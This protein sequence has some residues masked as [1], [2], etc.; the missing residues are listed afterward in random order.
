MVRWARISDRSAVVRGVR[1]AVVHRTYRLGR[2]WPHL[3]IAVFDNFGERRL[4][5]MS[6]R[7]SLPEQGFALTAFWQKGPGFDPA[8]LYPIPLVLMAD[9]REMLDEVEGRLRGES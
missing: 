5:E 8:P 3:T 6:G 7:G 1:D 2:S 9:V 4:A